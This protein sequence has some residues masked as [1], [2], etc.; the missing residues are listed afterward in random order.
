MPDLMDLADL[1]FLCFSLK[2]YF[3]AHINMG[4][5]KERS[6]CQI[7]QLGVLVIKE[8]LDY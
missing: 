6:N 8:K 7:C 4:K 5:N 3:L 1:A 2:F